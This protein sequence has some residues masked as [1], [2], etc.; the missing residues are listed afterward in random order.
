M[1]E[2]IEYES[3]VATDTETGERYWDRREVKRLVPEE[4]DKVDEVLNIL[5]GLTT[6]EEV[7]KKYR[8]T[9]LNSI[10]TWI[11]KYVSANEVLSL[12]DQTEEEMAK[13]SKDDQIRELKAA[14]K[15]AQ[16]EA[17]I[18]RLRAHAYDTM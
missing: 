8:I 5:Q 13:K 17:E 4:S 12:Q 6:P 9:S 16:K 11:G 3:Y 15:K 7:R 10:Y 14:L 2:K 1:K 18:E